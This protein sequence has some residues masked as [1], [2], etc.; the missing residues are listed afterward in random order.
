M[1][2]FGTLKT[3][4]FVKLIFEDAL[5]A[6]N[7]EPGSYPHATPRLMSISSTAKELAFIS[8]ML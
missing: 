6:M 2:N 8:H 4:K 1:D 7:E 3:S 5:G